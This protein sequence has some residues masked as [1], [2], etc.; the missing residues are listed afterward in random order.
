VLKE[1]PPRDDRD[2]ARGPE[3]ERAPAREDEGPVLRCSACDAPITR[4]RDRVERFGAH[5]HDRVNP[6][7]YAFTIGCFGRAD[8]ARAVGVPSDDFPWFPKHAWQ[9]AACAACA[10]HL[11]WYFRSPNAPPFFGLI[12]DKL[13]ER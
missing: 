4:P 11:G 3:A 6:G 12:V 8:G 13:I 5:L 1:G 9:I 7:G 10:A 2:D